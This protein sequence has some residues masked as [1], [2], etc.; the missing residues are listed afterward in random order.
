MYR[1]DPGNVYFTWFVYQ[2]LSASSGA[3]PMKNI[4]TLQNY[5]IASPQV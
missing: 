1:A 4:T 2:H 3:P 5:H